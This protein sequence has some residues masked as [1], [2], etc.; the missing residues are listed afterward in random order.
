LAGPLGHFL[1]S[2]GTCSPRSV[3]AQRPPEGPRREH[4]HPATP[5][6]LSAAYGR[7]SYGVDSGLIHH[8]QLQYCSALFIYL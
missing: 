6:C 4:P 8:L 2:C 7:G 3:P 1:F 5:P